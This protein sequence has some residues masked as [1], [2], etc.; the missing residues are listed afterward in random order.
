MQNQDVPCESCEAPATQLVD[1]TAYCDECL[2][3]NRYAGP[4]SDPV[5]DVQNYGGLL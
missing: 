2:K 3:A 4:F 1:R 5:H